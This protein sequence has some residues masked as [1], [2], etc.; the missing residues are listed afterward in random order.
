MK[1]REILGDIFGEL[2]VIELIGKKNNGEEV[3][4]CKCSCGNTR[5]CRKSALLY[6]NMNNCGCKNLPSG[7]KAIDL[8]GN[9]LGTR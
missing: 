5:K 3:Y 4:L 8:T 6:E 1:K 7:K 2:T 9:P